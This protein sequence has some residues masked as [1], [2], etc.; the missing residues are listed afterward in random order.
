[1]SPTRYALRDETARRVT[2]DRPKSLYPSRFHPV[3]RCVMRVCHEHSTMGETTTVRC[4]SPWCWLCR[5]A[6]TP[7]PIGARNCAT[8]PET[9]VTK[10][11][12]SSRGT[13]RKRGPS[14]A[15]LRNGKTPDSVRP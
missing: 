11:D 6:L 4:G 13:P 15:L 9:P 14:R 2:L 7:I 1:M 8:S 3:T 12:F 10:R 5:R